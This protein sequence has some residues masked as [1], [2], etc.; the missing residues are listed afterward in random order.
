MPTN[1]IGDSWSTEILRCRGTIFA[2][3]FSDP[4]KEV[5]RY[6]SH[7]SSKSPWLCRLSMGIYSIQND[8]C[9]YILWRWGLFLTK[10]FGPH[11]IELYRRELVVKIRRMVPGRSAVGKALGAEPRSTILVVAM[12]G[13]AVLASLARGTI[14]RRQ[15]TAGRAHLR[16][17]GL[18]RARHRWTEPP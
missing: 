13:P 8:S 11:A 6:G 18:S 14:A 1:S 16:Q 17:G 12:P 3:K 2:A 10:L 9:N 4:N 15:R 7:H 5:W